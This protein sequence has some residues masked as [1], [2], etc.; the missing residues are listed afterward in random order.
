MFN[1]LIFD[2]R[3]VDFTRDSPVMED[4]N[5]WRVQWR[6][7]KTANNM[8]VDYVPASLI[9]QTDIAVTAN[10]LPANFFYTAEQAAALNDRKAAGSLVDFT[11]FYDRTIPG[12]MTIEG[13]YFDLD[14]SAIPLI[15]RDRQKTTAEGE[16]VGHSAAFKTLAGDDV[17]FRNINMTGNGKKATG[18][19]DKIYGGGI[20]FVKGAGSKT[21]KAYNMIATKFYITFFG[22]DG[23]EGEPFTQF[24]LDKVKCFD[25]YNSFLYNWGSTITAKNTLFRSCG[26]PVLIQ[27]HTDTDTYEDYSYFIVI[28]GPCD[29]SDF[30]LYERR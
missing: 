24:E 8:D 28:Y 14:F 5:D 27:D 25:N 30:Y 1:L 22:E 26:G 18:D 9:F 11:F 21:L 19:E 3:P 7:F 10:D 23:S 2:T 6:E 20:I 15:K 16:V 29:F 4:G 17:I 12:D 13:N